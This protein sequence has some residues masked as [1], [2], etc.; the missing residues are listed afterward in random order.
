MKKAK[1]SIVVLLTLLFVLFAMGSGESSTDTT[2]DQGTGSVEA[3]QSNA[4]TDLGNYSVEILDSRLAKDFAGEDVVIIKYKFTNNADEPTAFY[5]AFEDAAYQNDI[6]LNPSYVVDDSAEYSADNQTKEIK[7]GA[8]LE[9]EVAYELNDT[10]SDVV[11]EVKELISF[12]DKTITK[13][14]TIAE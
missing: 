1:I 8:S 3:T 13:T 11:V 9:V 10:T 12:D 14:F 4:D 7:K 6:G 5:Y 2:V